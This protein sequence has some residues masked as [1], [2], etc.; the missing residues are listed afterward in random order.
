MKTLGKT[1]ESKCTLLSTTEPDQ[2]QRKTAAWSTV[3]TFI[4]I[5]LPQ[6]FVEMFS[7][8]LKS[9]PPNQNILPFCWFVKP[10]YFP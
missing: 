8:Y 7:F 4:A 10:K 6:G 2:T 5:N 1:R 9:R 3:K